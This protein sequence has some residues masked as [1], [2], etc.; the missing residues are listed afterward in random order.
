MVKTGSSYLSQS[1]LPVTFGV[2]RRDR[3]DRV[4]IDW[5]S[6]RTEE[7]KSVQAGRAYECVEGKGIGR[8]DKLSARIALHECGR[9]SECRSASRAAASPE[10]REL[11]ERADEAARERTCRGVRGAKPL[12]TTSAS[13]LLPLADPVVIQSGFRALHLDFRRCVV[14][15]ITLPDGLP[16]IRGL[17]TYSPATAKPIG[18]LAEVLLRGPSTLTRG[19]REIDR[20]ARVVQKRV[21]L[22]PER[23]RRYRRR[24]H[25]GRACRLRARRARQAGRRVSAEYP[26]R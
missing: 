2:G 21:P 22:L 17:L 26:R 5:P 18:D 16:G 11:P 6:G 4:V 1:E 13:I 10:P 12:G 24:A 7:F 9:S 20:H 8:A 15:H 25:G 23:P 19:E 14:A 3:V